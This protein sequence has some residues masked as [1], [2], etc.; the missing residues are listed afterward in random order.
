[1]KRKQRAIKEFNFDDYDFSDCVEITG[2]ALYLINGGGTT[3]ESKSDSGNSQGS[4]KNGSSGGDTYT[5]QSGNTL[6]QIVSDYNEANGTNLTVAQVAQ[7]SGISNPDQIYPGQQINFGTSQSQTQE[8]SQT[9]VDEASS[10]TSDSFSSGA[11]NSSS[12][13]SNAS[14]KSQNHNKQNNIK[15]YGFHHP[16][17]YSS[18]N[19]LKTNDVVDISNK[20]NSYK[21]REAMKTRVTNTEAAELSRRAKEAA[22][23]GENFDADAEIAKMRGE[24]LEGNTAGTVQKNVAKKV[25]AGELAGKVSNTKADSAESEAGYFTDNEGAGGFGHSGMYVKGKD[26]KYY[27]FEVIGVGDRSNNKISVDS[28][29]GTKVLDAT[30]LETTILSNITDNS[31]PSPELAEKIGKPG[32]AACLM[33]V[34]DTTEDMK[35]GLKKLGF[36]NYIEFDIT[37]EQSSV[38]LNSTLSKGENFSNYHLLSNSCGGWAR[39][40]LCTSGSEIK[41]FN[42]YVN[43]NYIGSS[44]IPKTIGANLL[45]GNPDSSYI[46]FDKK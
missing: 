3:T 4:G 14:D 21:Y 41:P 16:V 28:K 39:D 18:D 17:E 40:V 38:I 23:A 42:S 12:S 31:F 2:D 37:P 20:D 11:S 22:A 9:N 15:K 25:S 24:S 34:F 32:Q 46:E 45:L 43:I 29:K 36:D 19:K 27:T 7:N 35:T 6:S 8:V 44:A 13:S 1:M 5:V 30:G 10:K 26:S 33:R